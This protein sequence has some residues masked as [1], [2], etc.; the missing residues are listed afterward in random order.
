MLYESPDAY[1]RI[2]DGAIALCWGYDLI[3]SSMMERLA[4]ALEQ[5]NV[6]YYICPGNCTWI[7]MTGR[8]DVASFNL[9]TCGEIGKSHGAIGYMV[10]DW[11]CGEGHTHFP[12]WSLVPAALGAQ[13]SW[14]V[15]E[16]QN[17]G[18]LKPHNI[19][20][21][22]KRIILRVRNISSTNFQTDEKSFLQ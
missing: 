14:H 15:G 5:K 16:K 2:P 21:A 12:V 13:Y 11:G 4:T 19:H 18:M 17:G 9:R 6:P 22:E 3:K 1:K 10:T 7:S 8:F 20:N